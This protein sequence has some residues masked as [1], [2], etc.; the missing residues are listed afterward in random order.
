M[1]DIYLNA[2]TFGAYKRHVFLSPH[3]D[4]V[5]WSCG[6]LIDLL[7]KNRHQIVIVTVFDGEPTTL[8]PQTPLDVWRTIARPRL[9]RMENENVIARLKAEHFSLEFVDGALRNDGTAFT[10][11]LETLFHS[12]VGEQALETAIRQRLENILRPGDLIH[13]PL[14]SGNH[15]DHQIVRSAVSGRM[16]QQ[17]AYY[18]DFPYLK[19]E[20]LDYTPVYQSVDIRAWIELATL[21]RSQVRALFGTLSDFKSALVKRAEEFGRLAGGNVRWAYRMWLNTADS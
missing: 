7:S 17:I 15:L 6:G 4:D 8:P 13:A 11:T 20:G 3:P 9:R 14:A 19:A 2:H 5:I 10:Y 21:Y 16:D 12:P 18:D 1:K